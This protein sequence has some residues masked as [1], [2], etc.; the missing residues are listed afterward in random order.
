MDLS[1]PGGPRR[2]RVGNAG[3][4][5][6]RNFR[7]SLGTGSTP[8]GWL[9]I[10]GPILFTEALQAGGYLGDSGPPR[11]FDGP[12]MRSVLATERE[13]EK[14]DKAFGKLPLE[15]EL[16][17]IPEWLF[18]RIA[19]TE[20]PRG[21]AAFV[22]LPGYEI[23]K[24]LGRPDALALVACGLQDPGN[25]GTIVR[26]AQALGASAL[27]ALRNTVS[28]FNVKAVR[29]SAGAIFHLPVFTDLDPAS[30][31]DRL[32]QLGLKIVAADRR[33][34]VPLQQLDLR[35]AFALL[36]GQ[37][38]AGLDDDLS[39]QADERGAIPIR[40]DMDSLNAAA[41]AS[42]FLFEAARQ[43]GFHFDEPV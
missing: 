4:P 7:R 20:S 43:R 41:A 37:E 42:I 29:S 31:F 26:S 30:I 16:T 36:I 1:R 11:K 38:A 8:E 35:G 14:F 28:P 24:A 3:H 17:I 32:R 5:L 19:Q 23:D 34:S 21:I 2:Q 25:L 39:R 13:A 33:S 10:E 18:R 22:E 12:K 40:R 27:L 9:A 6:I 15:C